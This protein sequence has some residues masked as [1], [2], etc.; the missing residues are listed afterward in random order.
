[1]KIL[2]A[3]LNPIVGDIEGNTSR[4]INVIRKGKEMGADLVVF[5]ELVITGYPPRDL[6]EKESFV[7]SNLKKLK[8]LAKQVDHPSAIVGFI[9]KNPS[10]VGK[11][12]FNAAALLGKGKIKSIHHKTK[13]LLPTY[14]V[15]D[16][17]RYFEAAEFVHLADCMGKKAGISI[18]E[19]AWNDEDFWQ[20]RRY[21]RDP[22]EEQVD[23]GAEILIN[24]SASPYSVGKPA[25]R[26]RMLSSQSAKYNKAIIFVN[27]TG[28]ND[29]LIFDGHSYV[30]S[31]KGSIAY[32]G[33]SFAED[34]ILVD[35]E[36]PLPVEQEKEENEIEEVYKALILGTGDYIRK[37]GFS[38]VVMGI[39]G[40]IDSSV[41][42]VLAVEAIGAENIL[43]VMMP[44]QYSSKEGREDAM[45]LMRNLGIES[46]TI[47]IENIFGSYLKELSGQFEGRKSDITEENIQA[48]IR[49]NILMAISN[50]FGHLVLATGNKSEMS[51]GYCTLYGDMSGGLA[52]I[53]DVPKTMVYELACFINRGQE[54]IP[55]RVLTKAPSAELKPDQT[56]QDALPP[57][58]ILD[59]ILK[60]YIENKKGVQEIAAL[61]FEE[62]LAKKVINMVDKNEYKRN[63]APVGL[64]ITTKAFGV[65]RRMPIAQKFQET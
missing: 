2:M 42:A 27:Q 34:L 11:R 32:E 33:R 54:I 56:D 30:F 29:D 22:I 6:V 62:E 51:V 14:D 63:Q 28:G 1:M 24:L 48:R 26:K 60:H 10:P 37:C 31:P 53:S 8:E 12:V 38:K 39:S 23:M 5:P 44:S 64:K 41:V 49:G 50:K 40:G 21:L 35:L 15:F 9:D 13:T 18:C 7:A 16:E 43:G 25:L 61:G 20:E 55:K 4:V 36:K 52:I 19:D 46:Q 65:G 58:D 47:P 45:Q 3:Q 59:P 57:Y 17:G